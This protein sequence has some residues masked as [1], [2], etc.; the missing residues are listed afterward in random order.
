MTCPC[1]NFEHRQGKGCACSL[2]ASQ[3]AIRSPAVFFVAAVL[4]AAALGLVMDRLFGI[5]MNWL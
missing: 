5:P 2:K 1:P 3:D 4:A